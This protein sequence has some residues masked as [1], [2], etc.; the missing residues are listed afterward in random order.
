MAKG[1]G[2]G[3]GAL[4]DDQVQGWSHQMHWRRDTEPS[5]GADLTRSS[6][7]TIVS[8]QCPPFLLLCH[9]QGSVPIASLMSLDRSPP[10]PPQR[11]AVTSILHPHLP[12]ALEP[13]VSRGVCRKHP[14][15]PARCTAR[16]R[17]SP[18]DHHSLQCLIQVPNICAV[19]YPVGYLPKGSPWEVTAGRRTSHSCAH[20]LWLFPAAK[21]VIQPLISDGF[22]AN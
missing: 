20:R 1:P 18:P 22:T 2:E 12:P 10:T 21:L 11:R 3:P 5:R 6:R 17:V 4:G 9:L 15:E 16:G 14:R 7:A 19:P 8:Q 13:A